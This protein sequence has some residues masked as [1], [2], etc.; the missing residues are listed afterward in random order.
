MFFTSCWV[1]NLKKHIKTVSEFGVDA[2]I[3]ATPGVMKLAKEIAPHIEVHLS[4]QANV[5]NYLD[6]Q[7]YHDMGASRIRHHLRN[8]R[9][10]SNATGPQM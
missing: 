3:I 9:A 5:M 2:F 4:T 6:A 7:I 1:D 10:R 8:K